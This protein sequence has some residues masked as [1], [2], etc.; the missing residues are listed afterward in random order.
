MKQI[1]AF[2]QKEAVLCIAILLAIGTAFLIPPSP[3]Y[4][5]YIDFRTLALLLSLM[6]VVAGLSALGV[7]RQ[8]ACLLL[9]GI[10]SSRTLILTL[11]FLCFFS[12]MCITNDV[13]LITFVPFAIET[14]T[15]AKQTKRLIPV[16]IMQT[17]AANLGSMLTPIGNPQNLYLF[18]IGNKSI[19]QFMGIMLPYT[20][21]AAGMLLLWILL[22]KSEPLDCSNVTYQPK[23]IPYRRYKLLLYLALFLLCM[24]TIARLI[25]YPVTLG[26]VLL[27]LLLVDRKLLLQLDYCLLLTFVAFFI[28]VG[29][30][31]KLPAISS[32]L[33]DVITG[34]EIY[35]S[36]LLSQCISNMPAALLLSGFSENVPDILIGVNLGGLGTLIA[37]MASL[38][39]FKLYAVSPNARK[40]AYLLRFT[41]AG[42]AFLAVYLLALQLLT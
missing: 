31:S 13:A 28:F 40:G 32:F 18:G 36:M 22:L 41:L 1:K 29:N 19:L 15:L 3:D 8:T 37:S 35:V 33:A 17:L 25:P 11:V 21:L 39:A 38:I 6:A 7:F 5:S 4:V 12:G 26:I 23:H 42:L 9:R 34:R 30:L 16:V 24:L 27:C 14:L 2:I 20:L 10:H